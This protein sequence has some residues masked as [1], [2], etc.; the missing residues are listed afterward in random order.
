MQATALDASRLG[1]R[2]VVLTDGIAAVD[3]AEGD[4]QRALGEMRLA[5]AILQSSRVR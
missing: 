1:F 5:G 3:V 2:V 4:G